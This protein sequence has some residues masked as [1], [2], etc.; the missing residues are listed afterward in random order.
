M[1][2]T[3][4]RIVAYWILQMTR[5]M[6][7]IPLEFISSKTIYSQLNTTV[8]VNGWLRLNLI[9]I[10]GHLTNRLKSLQMCFSIDSVLETKIG[11]NFICWNESFSSSILHISFEYTPQFEVI[12]MENSMLN[13]IFRIIFL[14][15]VPNLS[16]DNK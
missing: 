1:L 7:Y 15:Y 12:S 10:K 14:Q 4:S 8:W 13:A 2:F 9:Q 6:P 3:T 5:Q 16:N 11:I